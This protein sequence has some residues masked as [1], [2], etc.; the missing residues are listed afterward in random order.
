MS[1]LKW[2][3]LFWSWL[4]VY[5]YLL[6]QLTIKKAQLFVLHVHCQVT[7][8][9]FF[10]VALANQT[11]FLPRVALLWFDFL[12]YE[13]TGNW[14]QIYTFTVTSPTLQILQTARL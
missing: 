11:R 7:F 9:Y 2:A 5:M 1:T 10:Y 13:A 12:Q 3:V 4:S 14:L 8:F 6:L